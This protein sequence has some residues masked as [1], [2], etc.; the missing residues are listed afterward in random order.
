MREPIGRQR[1][2]RQQKAA[3]LGN[4]EITP[5]RYPRSRPITASRNTVEPRRNRRTLRGSF[6]IR[7]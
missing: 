1:Q 3:D 5:S 7:N 6:E 4:L 2:A